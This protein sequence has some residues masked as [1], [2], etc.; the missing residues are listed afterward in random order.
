MLAL[1]IADE[2]LREVVCDVLIDHGLTVDSGTSY[3]SIV[4]TLQKQTYRLV[5]VQGGVITEEQIV[6]INA[7]AAN[8]LVCTFMQIA[9]IKSLNKDPLLRSLITGQIESLVTR[10]CVN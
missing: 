3:S 8:A 2:P 5:F 1:V 6:S 10:H 4:E 9:D 7:L